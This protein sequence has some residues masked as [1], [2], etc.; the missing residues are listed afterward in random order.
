MTADPGAGMTFQVDPKKPIGGHILAHA[1][2]T[3]IML[4]KGRGETRIAK[5]CCAIG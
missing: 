3:R 5:V 1:S 4:K 2:T